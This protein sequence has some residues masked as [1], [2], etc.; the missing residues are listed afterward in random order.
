MQKGEQHDITSIWGGAW[1]EVPLSKCNN[2]YDFTF[3][4]GVMVGFLY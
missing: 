3:L 2:L 4:I 1:Q